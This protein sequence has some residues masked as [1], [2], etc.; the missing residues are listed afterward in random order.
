AAA[1]AKAAVIQVKPVASGESLVVVHG[2]LELTDIDDFRI[3]V[4]SLPKATVAFESDGG[5][6]IAGIR[7]GSLIRQKSLVTVVPDGAQCASACAI[8]WLGGARR[9]VGADARVGF[10]AAYVYEQ[11][12]PA[13]SGPGNAVL[14]AYLNQL[15]LP[16]EA[17]VYITQAA[18]NAMVWLNTRDAA[19]HGID[20]ASLPGS[21][22]AK[23]RDLDS[24][25]PDLAPGGLEQR[26]M[27]FV[28]SLI[29][30]WSGPN[31]EALSGLG[32]FY[33]DEVIYY[34]KA[35]SR[36][37]ILY[38]KR[39]FADRWPQRRYRIKPGSM[40]AT[41]KPNTQTCRAK[42]SVEWEFVNAS[43][44]VAA[45]SARGVATFDYTVALDGGIPKITAE[46]SSFNWRQQPASPNSL[47]AVQ[48]SLKKLV[49]Q[50]VE[51]APFKQKDDSR[52]SAGKQ[53]SRKQQTSR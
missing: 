26:T 52:Q 50:I 46:N 14:G 47:I 6:L 32:E 39:H 30:R 38:D 19:R 27:D 18:P 35:T 2:D 10:H 3:K 16:E 12:H 51:L 4:A 40:T 49:A 11:G 31:A 45:A 22:L 5:S 9:Y 36:S 53:S 21:T 28:R 37:W 13:E 41:C 34:G 42:G 1:D 25:P 33:S 17:I 15:G 23:H 8:A 20:V 43:K 44:P 24:K 29:A 48:R 7:I